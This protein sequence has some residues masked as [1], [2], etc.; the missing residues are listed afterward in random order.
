MSCT[1]TFD[2]VGP[3]IAV[4]VG[5]DDDP[6]A[7]RMS[8]RRLLGGVEVAVVH[9][10]GH[11]DAA[12]RIDVDVRRIEEHR[13]LRPER[14]LEIVGQDERIVEPLCRRAGRNRDESE[15]EQTGG[16]H[17]GRINYSRLASND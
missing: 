7:C 5:K 4:A 14:N 10:L 3:A 11:P 17:G 15:E 9:R 12:A 6:V 2:V 13:R 16:T 8:E 1:N